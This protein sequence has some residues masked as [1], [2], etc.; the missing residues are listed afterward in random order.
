[1]ARRNLSPTRAG[2]KQTQAKAPMPANA[3]QAFLGS[4][5][6]MQFIRSVFL[7]RFA[8]VGIRARGTYSLRDQEHSRNKGPCAFQ[9]SSEAGSGSGLRSRADWRPA[10]SV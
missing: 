8:I 5:A 4:P 1:M 10:I 3:V 6:L 2:A 7:N 9:S